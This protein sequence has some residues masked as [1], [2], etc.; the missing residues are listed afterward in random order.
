MTQTH[1][2]ET[3]RKN[4]AD[5]MTALIRQIQRMRPT[6][7]HHRVWLH[8]ETMCIEA[9]KVRTALM[10]RPDGEMNNLLGDGR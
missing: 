4:L 5:D 6:A 10:R 3:E 9:S 1:V 8:L 7:L 2:Q